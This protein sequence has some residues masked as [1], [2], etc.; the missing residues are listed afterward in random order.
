M[1]TDS[2]KGKNLRSTFTSMRNQNLS[3][4][5]TLQL[6][7]AEM[8]PQLQNFRANGGDMVITAVAY[9][10]HAALSKIDPLMLAMMTVNVSI[11]DRDVVR[12]ELVKA[13]ANPDYAV[14]LKN[15]KDM[16]AIADS[17]SQ[18]DYVAA[19]QLAND[20][21]PSRTLAYLK[22]IRGDEKKSVEAVA[23]KSWK[24]MKTKTA[25]QLAQEAVASAARFPVDLVTDA[26]IDA[27]TRFSPQQLIPLSQTFGKAVTANDMAQVGI[28]GAAFLEESMASI[29]KG[30]VTA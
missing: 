21:I 10:A 20:I 7:S 28:T 4:L 30:Q 8:L 22:A 12:A 17:L 13:Y 14:A 27:A 2:G 19:S 5:E 6:V 11:P 29:L 24:E 26:V 1:S 3:A 9:Q 16:K 18:A 15:A 23:K 25:E